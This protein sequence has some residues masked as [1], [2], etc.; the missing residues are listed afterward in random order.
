MDTP[1]STWIRR[2]KI[3]K[4][5]GWAFSNDCVWNADAVSVGRA[6][7]DIT[8][9]E[10]VKE[11]RGMVE[12]VMEEPVPE[13]ADYSPTPVAV[14]IDTVRR[15]H[16]GDENSSGDQQELV[17]IIQTIAYPAAVVLIA[18]E[19]KPPGQG[20]S[21]NDIRD[22]SRGS[23][24][25]SG[26]VDIIIRMKASKKE[27]SFSW[28]GRDLQEGQAKLKKNVLYAPD[29]AAKKHGVLTWELEAPSVKVANVD[30]EVLRLLGDKGLGSKH[31]IALALK[32][33]T[34]MGRTAS[35]N[36]VNKFIEKNKAMVME[37]RPDLMGED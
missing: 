37:S 25:I 27:A 18:H 16:L 29:D 24:A 17:N 15:I 36:R 10:H 26:A 3:L 31:A 33:I 32:E 13:G 14:F 19:R 6:A 30:E 12:D 28:M 9:P 1:R 5:C 8:N 34:K 22:A 35:I 23:G 7:L 21:N 4:G 20:G 2:F 11:L